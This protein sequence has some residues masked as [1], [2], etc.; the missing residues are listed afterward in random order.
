MP[1]LGSR[2]AGTCSSLLMPAA[3]PC[4]PSNRCLSAC[5]SVS[6]M[7]ESAVLVHGAGVSPL[8]ARNPSESVLMGK[9]GC[10]CLEG[11]RS[12]FKSRGPLILMT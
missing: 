2:A 7:G 5:L 11:Q 9:M 12:G 1:A 8:L 4:A 6:V 3:Y 10:W